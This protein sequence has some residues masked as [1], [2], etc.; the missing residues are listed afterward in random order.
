MTDLPMIINALGQLDN[1]NAPRSA[2]AAAQLNPSSEQLTVDARTL[3][4]ARASSDE[5]DISLPRQADGE[6]MPV[7]AG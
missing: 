1:P 5:A 3:A 4:D 2:E 6:R 7:A